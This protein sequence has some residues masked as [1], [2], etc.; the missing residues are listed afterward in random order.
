MRDL[1]ELFTALAGNEFRSRQ[2]LNRKD[3]A[4]LDEKSLSTLTRHA[5]GFIVDR[6][7]PTRHG[8]DVRR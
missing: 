6:L 8:I 7:A 2:K 1:D 5:R 4:Y 3:R